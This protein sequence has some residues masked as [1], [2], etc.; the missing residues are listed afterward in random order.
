MPSSSTSEAVAYIAQG[1]YL[2][3]SG[4]P[5]SRLEE[6]EPYELG[7]RVARAMASGGSTSAWID[8]PV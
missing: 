3:N 2:R 6:D 8:I 5:Q 4:Y 1:Y 7:Y